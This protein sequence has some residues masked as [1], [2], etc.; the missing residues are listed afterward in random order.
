VEIGEGS[1]GKPG[2]RCAVVGQRRRYGRATSVCT[3]TGAT[4]VWRV[5]RRST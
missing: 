1:T 2:T 4:L 3:R 5:A